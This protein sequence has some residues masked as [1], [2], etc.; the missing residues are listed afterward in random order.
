VIGVG[1][2]GDEPRRHGIAEK[3]N[4]IGMGPHKFPG[5]S[6]GPLVMFDHFVFF[7][8]GPLL[9]AHAPQLARHVYG[10]NVRSLMVLNHEEAR[11]VETILICAPGLR[12]TA[13]TSW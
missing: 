12:S 5:S 2:T 11:E 4:W 6:R 1:G 8:K 9:V 13:V 7:E 10:K 3:I